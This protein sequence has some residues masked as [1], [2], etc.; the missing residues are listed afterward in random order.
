MQVVPRLAGLRVRLRA[1]QQ[2]VRA[3]ELLA[4]SAT[5]M[6]SARVASTPQQGG[7]R[8]LEPFTYIYFAV[9]HVSLRKESSCRRVRLAGSARSGRPQVS[10]GDRRLI[11]C[12]RP[13]SA[14]T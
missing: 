5:A 7:L 10:G 1:A 13:C 6:W 8:L 11:G 2:H 14:L 9:Q 12:G 4:L 3:A